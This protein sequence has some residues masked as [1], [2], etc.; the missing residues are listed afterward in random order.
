LLRNF[1]TNKRA[2]MNQILNILSVLPFAICISLA[3]LPSTPA[4]GPVV[5]DAVRGVRAHAEGP[6][7]AVKSMRLDAGG[8]DYLPLLQGPPEMVTMHSGLVVLAP[9]KSVG[10]H[11]TEGNEEIVIVLE[12]KGEMRFFT[13]RSTVPLPAGMAAYCP[14]KT[15]H[16]VFNTGKET[17]KYVYVVARA[18]D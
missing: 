10:T 14:P 12:G 15:E 18:G 6:A 4:A 17:L 11:G 2:S 7:P 3:A 9:G 16:D 5:A 1:G 8:K 13:G